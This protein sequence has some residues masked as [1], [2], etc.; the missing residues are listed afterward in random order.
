[1]I[2]QIPH[3]SVNVQM[4]RFSEAVKALMALFVDRFAFF[5]VQFFFF[6]MVPRYLYDCTLFLYF[7][8]FNKNDSNVVF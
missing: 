3:S 1:M 8:T 4:W 6:I 7:L 5:K 2:K